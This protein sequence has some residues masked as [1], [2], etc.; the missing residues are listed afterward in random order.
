MKLQ[1]NSN[2]IW[3]I[4]FAAILLVSTLLSNYTAVAQ[5]DVQISQHMFNRT[6]YNPSATGASNYVNAFFLARNQWV[7]WDGAPKTQ[8]ASVHSFFP[9]INS[10]LGVNF[11]NDKTGFQHKFTGKLMYAYHLKLSTDSYLSMGLGGGIQYQSIDYTQQNAIDPFDPD[12]TWNEEHKLTP[13]FD[14]GLEY[15]LKR[16]K[17]GISA[18]H[19]TRKPENDNPFS[20]GTHFYGYARY[21]IPI[22]IK[23][24]LAPSLFAQNSKGSTHFELGTTAHYKQLFWLGFFFR[25]DDKA[26]PESYVFMAGANIAKYLR[27]GYAFDLSIGNLKSYTHNSHEV[28]LA[29]RLPYSGEKYDRTPRFFE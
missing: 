11:I 3:F 21:D 18:T 15:N 8:I 7:G 16:L 9:S 27:I 4:L 6:Y 2:K 28:F 19:I 24:T 5:R 20:T 13:D 14:L 29:L 10:G 26:D 22:D 17:I 23:W 25:M 1:K 12:I